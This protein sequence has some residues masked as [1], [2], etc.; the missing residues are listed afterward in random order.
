MGLFSFGG[1]KSKSSSNSSSNTFVDPDQKP[2]L[3]DIRSQ[4]R[5][6]NNQGMPVQD[7]A[8]INPTLMNSLDLSNRSGLGQT[9]AGANLM[10]MGANQTQGT[11]NALNY[12]NNAMNSNPFG[13]IGTAIGS[14]NIFSQGAVGA[15]AANNSGIN[16]NNVGSYINNDIINGQVDAVSR[17]VMRNLTEYELP[18]IASNAA[19]TGNSGSSRAG[20][21]EGVAI[22]GAGD[23]V[24]DISTAL[25]A[26]AYNTA[27]NIG[28]NQ[29]SQN[30][31]FQQQTNIANQNAFN[32]ARQFGTGVGQNAFNTNLQNQQFGATTA[33]NIGQQG[34][35]NM[36]TGQNMMNTGIDRSQAS[37]Q[38]LRDYDQSLLNRSYE[39]AM[40]PFNSLNFYNQ[41]VGAPNNLSQAKSS[42]KGSSKSFSAGFGPAG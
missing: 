14:G 7:V 16:M 21:A 13:G 27:L 37:G 39:M 9:G 32:T 22:R 3:S 25:R 29:A 15:T 6:L 38:Y 24:A 19:G 31:G 5:D 33:N 4:A 35:S 12:A 2:Y 41:I 8:G 18:Q 20:I 28:A 30:A 10:G 11:G 1:S 26:P 40:S 17:D 42:S 23:R 36:T 34:V